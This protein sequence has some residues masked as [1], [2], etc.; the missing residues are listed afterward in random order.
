MCF[1]VPGADH[2]AVIDALAEEGTALLG[3]ATVDGR[4]AIRACIANYRTTRSDVD[5][6]LERLESFAAS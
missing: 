5:L 2:Q 1:R 3:P 6:I 4:P